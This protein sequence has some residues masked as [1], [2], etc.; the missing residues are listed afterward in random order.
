METMKNRRLSILL[1][2][3]LIVLLLVMI[4]GVFRHCAQEPSQ[5]ALRTASLRRGDLHITIDATGTIEPEQVI[6]VGAQVAG[7]IIS[8]GTDR[9]GKTV[10]YGS[11][12]RKGMVLANIDES[13]YATELDAALSELASAKAHLQQCEADRLVKLAKVRQTEQDWRRAQR[14]GPSEALARSKYDHYQTDHQ[15]AKAD[16][17]VSEAAIVQA[18][19]GISRAEAAVRRA[20]RN[21]GYCTITSPVDGLIID[22]RVNIGQTVVANLNAP[23]L[24][25]LAQDLTHMKIWAAVNEADVCRIRPG[26]RVTFTIDALPEETFSGSVGKIRLNA[27]M[28]QNVVIYTVEVD[29][30]NSHGRLLPYLTA[31]VT[32]RIDERSNVWL[33]PNAALN[34][35]P[36]LELIDP[37]SRPAFSASRKLSGDAATERGNPVIWVKHGKKVRPV[38]VRGGL[39]DGLMT[40]IAGDKLTQGLQIVVGLHTGIGKGTKGRRESGNPFVPEL[41]PPPTGDQRAAR[42]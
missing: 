25:L 30:E 4:A 33:V 24:F 11:V 3:F 40:E 2:A 6:D 18:E 41:P 23:S 29:I 35:Q 9:D 22:R 37:Q 39:S 17:S 12:V 14:I 19:A 28:T 26:Q 7:K 32:F 1:A 27:A 34:W 38:E 42:R 20:E 21:I 15:I 13:L 31:N 36:P 5:A 8:F 10:D 16:L